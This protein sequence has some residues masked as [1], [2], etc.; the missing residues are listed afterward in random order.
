MVVMQRIVTGPL[1]RR[2]LR[3]IPANLPDDDSRCRRALQTPLI[4]DP[5]KL[6]RVLGYDMH[7]SYR[8]DSDAARIGGGEP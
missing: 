7:L 1:K 8:A 3:F 2:A 5:E 4:E 6:S